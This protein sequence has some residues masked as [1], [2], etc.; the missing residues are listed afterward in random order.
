[1]WRGEAMNTEEQPPEEKSNPLLDELAIEVEAD[2]QLIANSRVDGADPGTPD[3]WL[4][5]PEEVQ[6]EEI[7]FRSL[8]T[9]VESLEPHPHHNHGDAPSPE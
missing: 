2:L 8:Q 4:D 9:A 7:D 3:H 1:M 6:V 5:D